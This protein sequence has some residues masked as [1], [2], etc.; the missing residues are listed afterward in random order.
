MTLEQR[1]RAI[2][3]TEMV[4]ESPDM[5]KVMGVKV[6]LY[7]TNDEEKSNS[8]GGKGALCQRTKLC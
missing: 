8:K 4:Q 5:A 7:L 6:N 2:R 3:L 1:M